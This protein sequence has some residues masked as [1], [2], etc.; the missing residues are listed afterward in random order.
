MMKEITFISIIDKIDDLPVAQSSMCFFSFRLIFL[1]SSI[2]PFSVVY[3]RVDFI[4]TS[5][6]SICCYVVF[7]S[8][9]PQRKEKTKSDDIILFLFSIVKESFAEDRRM[10]KNEKRLL[11]FLMPSFDQVHLKNILIQIKDKQ[12]SNKWLTVGSNIFQQN[13]IF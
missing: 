5:I 3:D 8:F 6:D 10:W 4:K 1:L 9:S 12:K 7:S 2:H 11:L 13:E